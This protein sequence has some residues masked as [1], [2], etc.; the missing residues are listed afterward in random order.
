MEASCNQHFL[1]FT[2]VPKRMDRQIGD[3][4]LY[5]SS[6]LSDTQLQ[7]RLSFIFDTHDMMIP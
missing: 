7:K 1:D 4:Q 3:L 5:L 6:M 2:V